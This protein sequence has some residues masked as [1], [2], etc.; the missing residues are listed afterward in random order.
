MML[1]SDPLSHSGSGVVGQI[2]RNRSMNFSSGVS[3]S[4]VLGEV[5]L[6]SHEKVLR[7]KKRQA[8][9]IMGGSG[10]FP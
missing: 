9:S 6:L 5:P 3:Q 1:P 7:P 10:F 8:P 4:M 2:I